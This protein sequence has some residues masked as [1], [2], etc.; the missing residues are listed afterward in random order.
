MRGAYPQSSAGTLGQRDRTLPIVPEVPGERPMTSAANALA[1]T[2]VDSR[3][4]LAPTA[5]V[6]PPQVGELA[7]TFLGDALVSRGLVAAGRPSTP[8][9]TDRDSARERL[10]A[11]L[12]AVLH[13]VDDE[14]EP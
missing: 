3:R 14:T 9:A 12:E 2:S 7:H 8:A 4:S 13:A 1:H 5:G 11:L 10:L 6:T